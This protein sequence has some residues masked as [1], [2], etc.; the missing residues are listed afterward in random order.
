[1]TQRLPM[2][3]MAHCTARDSGGCVWPWRPIVAARLSQ[4]V[5]C[6]PSCITK[7][8]VV[9]IHLLRQPILYIAGLTSF[10]Q[11]LS[12][13]LSCKTAVAAHS[14]GNSSSSQCFH[15]LFLAA[16]HV[17]P[18]AGWICISPLRQPGLYIVRRGRISAGTER[19]RE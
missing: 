4:P 2:A 3:P 19:E 12:V 8:W 18:K 1:M 9:C 15:S 14:F 7:G 6:C 10:G 13:S 5:P 11:A 16:Q 17:F